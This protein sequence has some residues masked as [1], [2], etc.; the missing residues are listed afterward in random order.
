MDWIIKAFS[1]LPASVSGIFATVIILGMVFIFFWFLSGIIKDYLKEKKG[2]S[3][4]ANSPEFFNKVVEIYDKIGELGE[5]FV[6]KKD[7]NK[8]IEIY[9]KIGE[10]GEKFV[11]KKDFNNLEEKVNQTRESLSEFKGKLGD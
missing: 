11:S 2:R 10:L 1:G 4:D 7:L 5:K 3:N 9:D 6:S 8:I